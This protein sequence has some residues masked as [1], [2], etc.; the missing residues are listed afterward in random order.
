VQ[1]QK[2]IRGLQKG[3][4]RSQRRQNRARKKGGLW[5]RKGGINSGGFGRGDGHL[6][7]VRGGPMGKSRTAPTGK[8]RL[9]GG[10]E[11]ARSRKRGKKREGE[12][13][14]SPFGN[15]SSTTIWG[16]GAKE[17]GPESF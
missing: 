15:F 8:L 7:T 5:R 17:A 13:I 10:N 6:F 9:P 2:R 11:P 12:A 4:K 16:G 14:V 3:I 1:N